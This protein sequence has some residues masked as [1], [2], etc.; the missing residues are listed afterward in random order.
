ML[1][2]NIAL[3]SLAALVAANEA[4]PEAATTLVA[5]PVKAED[6]SENPEDIKKF[7]K[8]KCPEETCPKPKRVVLTKNITKK[9]TKTVTKTTGSCETQAPQKKCGGKN[10]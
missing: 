4:A 2:K 8:H 6:N 7:M 9:A 10:C 3:I 1:F 5:V